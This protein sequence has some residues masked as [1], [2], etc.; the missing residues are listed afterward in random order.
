MIPPP[1]FFNHENKHI[2]Y[3][4]LLLLLHISLIFFTFWSTYNFE[5][6]VVS[7]AKFYSPCYT[8]KAKI[9]KIVPIQQFV[10][11]DD[12]YLKLKKIIRLK[13]TN[14]DNEKQSLFFKHHSKPLNCMPYK[15]LKKK[16]VRKKQQTICQIILTNK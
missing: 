6:S 3:F 12:I 13:K 14:N 11:K 2:L 4:L 9:K 15:C 10:I 1:Q 7:A 16:I 8:I 5:N